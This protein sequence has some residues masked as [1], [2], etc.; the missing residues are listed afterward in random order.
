MVRKRASGGGRKPKGEFSGKSA[1]FST[2]ITPDLRKALDR[3]AEKR[4][5]SLSQEIE[6]LLW[7]S[8]KMPARELRAWGPPPH[9]GLARAVSMLSQRVES[10]TGTRWQE[11]AFA[12]ETLRRAIDIFLVHLL[13]PAAWREEGPFN[14]PALVERGAADTVRALLRIERLAKQADEQAEFLRSPLGVGSSIA[15]GLVESLKLYD[16]PPWVHPPSK[17]YADEYYTTP[18]LRDELG[19][20]RNL[21]MKE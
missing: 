20:N 15:S 6:Q 17:H 11:D 7:E 21:E 3:E 19:I 10:V 18:K 13:A 2:R 1:V 12:F 4:G 8:I 5:H 9:I 16:D 14:V